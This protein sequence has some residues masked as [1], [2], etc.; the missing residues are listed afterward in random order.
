MLDRYSIIL[1][2]KSACLYALP[3]VYI[4]IHAGIVM[5]PS[6]SVAQQHDRAGQAA[7]APVGGGTHRPACRSSSIS[8]R[9][10]IRVI[11]RSITWTFFDPSKKYGRQGW[12]GFWARGLWCFCL[13]FQILSYLLG[14]IR[15]SQDPVK[16]LLSSSDTHH[17]NSSSSVSSSEAYSSGRSSV[18]L[19]T[20]GRVRC[21]NAI[22]GNLF[23]ATPPA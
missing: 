6:E 22:V 7:T 13:K 8:Y 11:A 15:R 21:N 16:T 5:V 23:T 2:A 18:D 12:L 19:D 17:P 1:S 10:L 20:T 14:S 3:G 9:P 4:L